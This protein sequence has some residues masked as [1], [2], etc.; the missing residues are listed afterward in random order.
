MKPFEALPP[1]DRTFEKLLNALSPALTVLDRQQ[2]MLYEP[3]AQ[4][5]VARA[6]DMITSR[7]GGINGLRER[8][9]RLITPADPPPESPG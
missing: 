1:T 7:F 3:D 4:A 6:L 9:V 5:W 2:L 8:L